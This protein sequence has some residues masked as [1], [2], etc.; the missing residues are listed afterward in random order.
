MQSHIAKKKRHKGWK[1]CYGH[2]WKCFLS[3]GNYF[4]RLL[5]LVPY[6]SWAPSFWV[7]SSSFSDLPGLTYI[8]SIFWLEVNLLPLEL[9]PNWYYMCATTTMTRFHLYSPLFFVFPTNFT[10]FW[11]PEPT[12]LLLDDYFLFKNKVH[13]IFPSYAANHLIVGL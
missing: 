6:T 1:S 12:M 8:S 3:A 11:V 4:S 2:L 10:L 13:R 5:P 7:L 9:N